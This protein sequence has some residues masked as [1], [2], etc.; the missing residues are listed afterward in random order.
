MLGRQA[1]DYFL[2]LPFVLAW[3]YVL[4]RCVA[5]AG[6]WMPT[7]TGVI[8]GVGLYRYVASW[9]V[10]PA[11]L[12]VTHGVLWRAA[13]ARAAHAALALGFVAALLPLGPG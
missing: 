5:S 11:L 7:L 6:V 9:I 10:M 1:T 12:L 8:L 4:P 2:P 13:K 3:L